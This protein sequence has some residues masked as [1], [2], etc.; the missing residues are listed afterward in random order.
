MM[1]IMSDFRVIGVM[2]LYVVIDMMQLMSDLH[3]NN[4]PPNR[5]ISGN[6]MNQAKCHQSSKLVNAN[7]IIKQQRY[8]EYDFI[9]SVVFD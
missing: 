8:Y 7:L 5:Y 4:P 3:S 6:H 9:R 2:L 1:I